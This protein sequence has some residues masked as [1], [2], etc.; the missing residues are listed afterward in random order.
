MNFILIQFNFRFMNWFKIKN[1]FIEV[2]IM[3]FIC[4][5]LITSLK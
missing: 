3:F 1:I 4:F 2:Y 5:K